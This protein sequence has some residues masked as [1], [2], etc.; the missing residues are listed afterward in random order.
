[1]RWEAE[2]G[3][4]GHKLSKTMINDKE[5]NMTIAKGRRW[6][7]RAKQRKVSKQANNDYVWI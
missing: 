4:R 7:E 5:G 3:R 2:H 1:M 6:K